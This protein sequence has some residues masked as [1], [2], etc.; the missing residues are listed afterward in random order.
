[1]NNLTEREIGWLA[2]A[3]D[4]EGNLGIDRNGAIRCSICNTD[5]NFILYAKKLMGPASWM[6]NQKVRG[7]RMPLYVAGL[8]QSREAARILSQIVSALIIKRGKAR[9]IIELSRL[10][11]PYR[12]GPCTVCGKPHACKGLCIGHYR[13]K[14]GKEIYMRYRLKHFGPPDHEFWKKRARSGTGQFI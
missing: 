12:P 13:E 10:K 6:V 2:A 5:K 7:N 8:T 14:Y 4:G 1:M 11:R 3:I 9:A